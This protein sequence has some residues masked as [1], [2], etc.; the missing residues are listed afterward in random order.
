M[1]TPAIITRRCNPYGHETGGPQRLLGG[2]YGPEYEGR[3]KW[4]CSHPATLRVRMSCEHG[5][6][7]QVMELCLPHAREIQRRQ[8]G[9]CPACAWPPEARMWQEVIE[10]L[11]NELAVLAAAGDYLLRSPQALRVKQRIEGAG[12]RMTEL[13][14]SGVIK[15]IPLTLT[16]VS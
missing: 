10:R 3:Y 12:Y 13:Y 6:R 14:Q 9:L 4:T 1:T 2:V 11:Q 7:G 5:H 15:K 8:A 16:E